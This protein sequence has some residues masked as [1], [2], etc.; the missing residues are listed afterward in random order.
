MRRVALT[1]LA[2]GLALPTA[3]PAK[4]P[5]PTTGSLLITSGRGLVQIR[6]KGPLIGRLEQGS[7]QITDLSPADQWSPIVK[8][9]PRGKVVWIRGANVGFRVPD[10]RYK[11]VVRGV[12]ISISAKGP[13][14][15]LLDGD[16]DM[17]GDTG[18]YAIGDAPEE[19][20]P[21]EATRLA[22]GPSEP[23]T[24]AGSAKI[25]P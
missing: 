11:I 3:V 5:A 14:H 12:G 4:D 8:G 13:G 19:P 6:G 24:S 1:L 15:V 9:V 10:G 21:V 18:T 2:L 22:F 20:L 17:V 16:P 7:L 23:M 25:S